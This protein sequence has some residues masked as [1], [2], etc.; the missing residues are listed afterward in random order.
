[1]PI[2]GGKSRKQQTNYKRVILKR[3]GYRCQLCGCGLG[4]VCNLHYAPVSQMDVAHI[5]PHSQDGLATPDNQRATCHPCNVRERYGS[6][7]QQVFA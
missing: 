7:R 2:R 5:V 4:Q 1:M 3:D 6:Q